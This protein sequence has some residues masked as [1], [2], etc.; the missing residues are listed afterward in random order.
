MWEVEQQEVEEGEGGP[1]DVGAEVR[2]GAG[3]VGEEG[4]EE[5]AHGILQ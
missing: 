3:D 1:A 2:H 4:R 5:R